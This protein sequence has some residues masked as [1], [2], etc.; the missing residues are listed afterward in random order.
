[1]SSRSGRRPEE[2][3]APY[4]APRIWLASLTSG[5]SSREEAGA[6][7]LWTTAEGRSR[8]GRRG[9][10]GVGSDSPPDDV[11]LAGHA[12]GPVAEGGPAVVVPCHLEHAGVGGYPFDPQ[13]RPERAVRGHQVG[14]EGFLDRLAEQ[15][16]LMRGEVLPVSLEPRKR[17]NRR[18][19]ASAAP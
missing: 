16:L 3:L 1:M 19:Q 14:H 7:R 11:G 17:L 18:H 9:E 12:F 2:G 15:R 10:D 6:A 8:A 5:V 13:A 4:L